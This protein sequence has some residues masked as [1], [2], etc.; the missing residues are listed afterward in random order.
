M[1]TSTKPDYG[2]RTRPVKRSVRL[3][4][5]LAYRQ[6]GYTPCTYQTDAIERQTA[7]HTT[8]MFFRWNEIICT[9]L[10]Q[11]GRVQ[12]SCPLPYPDPYQPHGY[13]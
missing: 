6:W 1:K 4:F 5:M 13:I 9:T 11:F 2:L 7:A 3:A 10:D 8:I 12:H